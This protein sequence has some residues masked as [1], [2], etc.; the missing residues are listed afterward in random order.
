MPA[1]KMSTG[2]ALKRF[3][4]EMRE[5]VCAAAETLATRRPRFEIY[6]VAIWTD[7]AA[8]LSCIAV[9]TQRHSRK[10]QRDYI[11][12]LRQMHRRAPD[13]CEPLTK[14]ELEAIRACNPASFKIPEAA[15]VE[16]RWFP[17][18]P[19]WEWLRP[20][21]RRIQKF[22]IAEFKHLRLHPE[23]VIGINSPKDW[24]TN[25]KPFRR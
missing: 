6:T 18:T 21:L 25:E 5:M 2:A 15:M 16:H 22:C 14:R 12:F 8:A 17:G 20:A 24:F 13:V 23:A 19:R 7:P 11:R 3:D 10:V 4:A 9:D 1:L